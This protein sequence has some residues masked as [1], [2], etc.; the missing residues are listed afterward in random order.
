MSVPA[1]SS[2]S[3]D[4]VTS[5][6]ARLRIAP[7]RTGKTHISKDPEWDTPA[8]NASF[9][10][11]T[12]TLLEDDALTTYPSISLLQLLDTSDQFST[13]SKEFSSKIVNILRDRKIEKVTPKEEQEILDIFL[14]STHPKMG[15]AVS[16][17][18]ESFALSVDM[19]LLTRKM[20]EEAKGSSAQS[21]EKKQVKKKD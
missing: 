3:S 13:D 2:T 15:E 17:F 12:K 14:K 5:A 20:F 10:R 11:L 4:A 1:L 7:M 19:V 21:Q 8:N 9:Q 6:M 18:G 16:A